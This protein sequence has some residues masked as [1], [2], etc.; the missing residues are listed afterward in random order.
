MLFAFVSASASWACSSSDEAAAPKADPDSGPPIEAGGPTDT[1]AQDS[2]PPDTPYSLAV[3]AD[4]P[5]LYWRL[6]ES[7]GS[8]ALDRSTNMLNGTYSAKGVL[9][10]QPSLV[11]DTNPSARFTAGG[12]VD[13][14]KDAKLAFTGTTA[15]S[16]ECWVSFAAPPTEIQTIVARAADAPASGY[17]MWLDPADAGAGARAY[18]GRYANGSGVTVATPEATPLEVGKAYHLI[19]TYDGAKVTIHLDGV[20]GPSADS[21]VALVDSAAQ[22]RIGRSENTEGVLAARVDELAIYGAVLPK[23]RIDA[24][25]ALGRSGP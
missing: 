6:E 8:V 24:H 16:V 22:I 10:G 5:L 7:T 25:V 4:K 18:F 9:L 2:A 19:A 12:S 14:S 17:S 23:D 3:L 21:T 15:F 11:K 20:A 1:G 13:G